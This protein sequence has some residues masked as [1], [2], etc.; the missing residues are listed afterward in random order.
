MGKI[1][2]FFKDVGEKVLDVGEKVV[3]ST[4]IGQMLGVGQSTDAAPDS[5]SIDPESQ[6]LID[7]LVLVMLLQSCTGGGLSAQGAISNAEN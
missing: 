4:G 7:G 1:G 6:A 2:R 3:G 5:G